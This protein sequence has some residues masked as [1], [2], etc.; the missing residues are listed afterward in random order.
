[1][2]NKTA[3]ELAAS[4][5]TNSQKAKKPLAPASNAGRLA[6]AYDW[7]RMEMDFRAGVKTL[8]QIASENGVSH[9]A[10]TKRA[11]KYGWTRDL[12]ARI[13][14]KAD[15][16]VNKTVTKSKFH[17]AKTLTERKI[18]DEV[19]TEIAAIQISQRRD[20]A[21]ARDIAG[22]L[23]DRLEGDEGK[24]LKLMESARICKMLTDALRGMVELER[25]AYRMDAKDAPGAPG[26]SLPSVNVTFVAPDAPPL[27][28]DE[29]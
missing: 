20:I 5:D 10:V 27:D 4:T 29:A 24:S 22:S 11:K 16:L 26:S 1:M 14:T 3:A 8:R 2:S 21:R 28:E 15:E 25:V 23:F 7:E 17:G 18:I 12:T 13:V 9:V 19:A 6:A